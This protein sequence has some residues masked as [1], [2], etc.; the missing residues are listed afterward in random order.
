MV[1]FE[2]LGVSV[3]V[4][5]AHDDAVADDVDA[6]NVVRE[7]TDGA[8]VVDSSPWGVLLQDRLFRFARYTSAIVRRGNG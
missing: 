3:V 5:A 2:E 1:R 8:D 7:L 6:L 4:S